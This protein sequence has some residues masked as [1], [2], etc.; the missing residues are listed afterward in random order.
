M[1]STDTLHITNS[2]QTAVEGEFGK[3]MFVSLVLVVL[4]SIMNVGYYQNLSPQASQVEAE[5]S[6]DVATTIL[7]GNPLEDI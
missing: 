7:P 3:K 4:L 1:M 6:K 2:K 5:L